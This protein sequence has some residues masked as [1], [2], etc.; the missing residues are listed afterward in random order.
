MLSRFHILIEWLCRWILPRITVSRRNITTSSELLSKGT[1][2]YVLRD[3]SYL[4]TLAFN[5]LWRRNNLPLVSFTGD[6]RLDPLG[7]F[8]TQVRIFFNWLLR[9]L[10][11]APGRP[12]YRE[13]LLAAV[14]GRGHGLFFLKRGRSVLREF[15]VGND[16]FAILLAEAKHSNQPI[17]LLPEFFI[18][19]P[20][21]DRTRA[22]VA[23]RFLGTPDEPG[24]LRWAWRI[25]LSFRTSVLECAAPICL[26]DFLAANPGD[27]EGL[28]VRK[29]KLA[30]L[31]EFAAER[32]VYAGPKLK[33]R[34]DLRGEILNRP[35]LYEFIVA[36]AEREKVPKEAV[37][38]RAG[39]ILDE[40][41]SDLYLWVAVALR[42]S[43]FLGLDRSYSGYEIDQE[44]LERVKA[45]MKQGPVVLL[46]NHASH[47]DYLLLSC[48]FYDNNLSLPQIA[49]GENLNFWPMGWL[50]RHSAAF[51]IR[52]SFAGDRLYTQIFD[53]YLNYL[54]SE[55]FPI[56]FFIEGTRSRNGRLLPP[57]FG[58]LSRIVGGFADGNASKLTFAPVG[59]DYDRIFEEGAYQRELKGGKKEKEG[60]LALLKVLRS[61]TGRRGRVYLRFGEFIDVGE[62]CQARGFEL[63]Q[64][65][66]RREA[67]RELAAEIVARIQ[68]ARTVTGSALVAAGLLAGPGG[69]LHYRQLLDRAEFFRQLLIFRKVHL[70]VDLGPEAPFHSRQEA[71]EGAL[72]RFQDAG[73]V[74]AAGEDPGD[75]FEAVPAHYL[76][77]DYY[78]NGLV[79]FLA[80]PAMAALALSAK[81][82]RQVRA[83]LE[84]SREFLLAVLGRDLQG[85]LPGLTDGLEAL[86]AAGCVSPDGEKILDA[87]RL[88][89]AA[90]VIRPLV[91]AYFCVAGDLA[92]HPEGGA[93][94]KADWLARVQ[95][96]AHTLHEA[97]KISSAHLVTTAAIDRAIELLTERGVLSRDEGAAAKKG[98]IVSVQNVAAAL[99]MVRRLGGILGI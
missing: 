12:S 48:T 75:T 72:V 16:P 6:L 40:M 79:N 9:K 35:A 87:G 74:L 2:F 41:A 46:P 76:Q 4:E 22:A 95:K 13:R 44:G 93:F 1:L 88:R 80:E 7:P 98:G 94:A 82:A 56:E 53:T 61:L 5:W 11:L 89:L 36:L 26:Q 77:L 57:Q 24:L 45:A 18:L 27:P 85:R 47:V 37:L 8:K 96:R 49:A 54:L 68:E 32:R 19:D 59:I 50:F 31:Q 86:A 83:G 42:H 34:L 33:P 3:R 51:F 69:P 28:L 20:T 15:F 90:S 30:V 62:F 38:A 84:T 14:R 52:R 78:R 71:L 73:Y 97:G 25:A 39:N 43:I 63:G 17:Y 66:T 23:E 21:P 70:G 60:P 10:R 67:T 58:M 29:L 99:E 91:E 81:D 65:A 64:S 92:A 55:N